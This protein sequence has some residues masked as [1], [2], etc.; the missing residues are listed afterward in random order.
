LHGAD[1]AYSPYELRNIEVFVRLGQRDRA[2]EILSGIVGDL[3]PQPWNGWQ[4]VVWRD[5]TAP[6]FI[7]DM[8]HTWVGA[9]FVQ[10]LRAMFAYEREDDTRTLVL[11][12][13]LPWDWVASGTGVGVKRLPTYYGVLSYTL[14]VQ[15]P[16]RLRMH[17][18]GDVSVPPTSIILQPPLPQPLKSVTVNGKPST[19]FDAEHAT[20]SEFP[21]DVVLEY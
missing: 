10:S 14:R 6:R 8:P 18:T 7:G 17:L 9:G 20:V 2:N 1:A 15:E 12:A 21:A 19:S 4:E 16:G 3:R 13:G 11:A 5:A